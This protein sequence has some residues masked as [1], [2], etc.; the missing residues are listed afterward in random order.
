[1]RPLNEFFEAVWHPTLPVS[2]IQPLGN[3]SSHGE[4]TS[5]ELIDLSHAGYH[6]PIAGVKEL[7]GCPGNYA[8]SFVAQQCDHIA[9]IWEANPPADRPKARA[10]LPQCRNF[11]Y[12][13][14]EG[15]PK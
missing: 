15:W 14:K 13:R 8:T 4:C 1:M 10:H 12:H 11:I 9:L 2:P 3:G 6:P 7:S 5:T